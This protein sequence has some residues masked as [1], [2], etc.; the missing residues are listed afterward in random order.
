MNRHYIETGQSI[1]R[2]TAFPLVMELPFDLTGWDVV[3][4]MRTSILDTGEPVV[5]KTDA[6]IE[7]TMVTVVLS[8]SDTWAIPEK[9]DKVFIQLNLVN[10]DQA[11]ATYVYAMSVLPNI[12]E[13]LPNSMEVDDE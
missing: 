1:T 11:K 5:Q 8:S 2:G 7:G 13:V 12:M 9:A 4:T 3:F 10:G 6:A